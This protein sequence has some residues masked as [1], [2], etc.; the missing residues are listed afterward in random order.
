M[1]N[2]LHLDYSNFFR[3][4]IK[5]IITKKGLSYY[6]VATVEEA[7]SVLEKH[8]ISLIITGL[9]LKEMLGT[10]FI[11]KLNASKFKDV[12][13]IVVTSRDSIKI[14][15]E[16]FSLG[17]VDYILKNDLSYQRFDRY[18]DSI[19]MEDQL[20]RDIQKLKIAV[21]DDSRH[22]LNVIKHIFELNKIYN[23]DYYQNPR[24]LL[25]C[26]K[27][28]SVYILDLVLPE[29]SGEDII[30]K[31][32][33]T[34]EQAVII[35]ISGISNFKTIS[36]VLIAGANDY[37]IKPF[38]ASIFMARIKTNVRTL[39]LMKKL[40]RLAIT[41][42]LTN[43][44]NH[45]HIV[46]K[47][48]NEIKKTS[49]AGYKVSIILFDLDHFKKVNDNFGH[50]V[51]DIVLIRI[52]AMVKA[53]LAKK[54]FVGRYGGEEFLIVLPGYDLDEAA[55]IAETLRQNVEA[56]RYKEKY[57]RTAISCGVAE[58]DTEDATELIKKADN[59]LYKAKENGRNRVEKE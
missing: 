28:Y 3:N 11:K 15:E 26:D 38:D 36:N 44:Y 43:V 16:L 12:P 19:F 32:R 58:L 20:C 8:D 23:V 47:L 17:V 57:L 34:N 1:L 6:G 18:I 13:L 50:V 56:L 45:K 21:L 37:V 49:K 31:I 41:D 51:G 4:V 29:F 2:V 5:D 40:E 33:K 14:R 55:K 22:S 7:L 46:G 10:D 30:L 25:E 52:A 35:S 9:E 42:S 59:L 39:F 53:A 27:R 24:D 48:D 54:G